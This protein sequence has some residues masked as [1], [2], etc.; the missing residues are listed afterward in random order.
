MKLNFFTAVFTTIISG[1]KKTAP[2]VDFAEGVYYGRWFFGDTEDL[3][4][5][6]IERVDENTVKLNF[7]PLTQYGYKIEGITISETS[8]LEIKSCNLSKDDFSGLIE[9]DEMNE[10]RLS[11]NL[12][13]TR[14][15]GTRAAKQG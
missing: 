11:W 9:K 2:K 1:Y 12:G 7:N 13:T 8:C 10:D 6:T 15:V 5:C 4:I 14:F 3:A